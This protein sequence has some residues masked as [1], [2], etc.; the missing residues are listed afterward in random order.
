MKIIEPTIEIITESNPLKR[1][2]RVGRVAYKSE[3]RITEN[4]YRTFIKMILTRGHTSVLE[5]GWITIPEHV[6]KDCAISYRGYTGHRY[7]HGDRI[8]TIVINGST[9]YQLNLR[10]F[11]NM[12]APSISE[13]KKTGALSSILMEKFI[14]Y[15]EDLLYRFRIYQDHTK[16]LTVNFITSRKVANQLIRS[17]TLSPTQESTRYV[18]YAKTQID[19]PSAKEMQFI[20]PLPYDWAIDTDNYFYHMFISNCKYNEAFYCDF[21]EKGATP[22]MAANFLPLDTK[23]ELILT[24]TYQWYSKMLALRLDSHAD[25]QNQYVV[26]KLVNHDDFPESIHYDTTLLN[27]PIKIKPLLKTDIKH[28]DQGTH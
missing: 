19:L 3:D 28:G 23:T 17:R 24:G 18:N 22:E 6:Y 27:E 11:Y 16:Y 13:N 26:R 1:I 20:L 15:V 12:Y 8:E 21:I 7:K 5:H 9:M 14:E 4:S 25:P 2:E 10:D